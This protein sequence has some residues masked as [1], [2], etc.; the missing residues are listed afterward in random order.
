[1]LWLGLSWNGG[2]SLEA[3]DA[4]GG[5]SGLGPQGLQTLPDFGFFLR[6]LFSSFLGRGLR[7]RA[8]P[9]PF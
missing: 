5:A 6:E 4:L 3:G 7:T 9:T 8:T 1:M 2:P